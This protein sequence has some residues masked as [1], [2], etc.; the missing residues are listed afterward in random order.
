MPADSGVPQTPPGAGRPQERIR[1][2]VALIVPEAGGSS[3]VGS[4]APLPWLTSICPL[5]RAADGSWRSAVP[6]KEHRCWAG[7]PPSPLPTA[8]QQELCLTSA[9]GGCERYLNNKDRR[10]AALA[11]DD[12]E[13][14][15]LETA[16]FGPFVSPVPVAVDARPPRPDHRVRSVVGRRRIPGMIIGGGVVLVG[17]VAL[18]AILGGSRL[19]GVAALPSPTV[20]VTGAPEGQVTPVPA[21]TADV[22]EPM[23]ARTPALTPGPTPAA[24]VAPGASTPAASDAPV[25]TAATR[26]TPTP[27]IA[28]KYTVKQ[29]DTIKSIA[30][31]FGLRPRDLRNV[32][33]I[34]KDVVVGQRLRIPV[35]T[36][37]E[38]VEPTIAPNP[39]PT[40]RTTPV[41]PAA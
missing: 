10:A 3:V 30:R 11:Q 36:A 37:A 7:E 15:R 13:I 23:I 25:P 21:A 9:H 34:G 39:Q 22:P 2:S 17:V 31:K 29:G 12:I 40:E 32:N 8:T 33:T 5:L 19:P 35:R 27:D 38:S 26:P 18:A 28:R 24:S 14:G 4:G 41:D 16:R 20:A 6:T 1:S